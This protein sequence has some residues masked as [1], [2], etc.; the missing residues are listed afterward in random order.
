MKKLQ[1]TAKKSQKSMTFLAFF[2]ELENQ[3]FDL[4]NFIKTKYFQNFGLLFACLKILHA[5]GVK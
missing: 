4:V 3:I 5:F 1:K 2:F